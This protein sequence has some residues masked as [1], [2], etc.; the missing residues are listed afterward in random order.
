LN[1][2]REPIRII[3]D[4]HLGYSGSLLTDATQLLPLIDGVGTLVFNGDTAELRNEPRYP[5]G[6]KEFIKLQE[7]CARAGV[8][9]VFLNGNHDPVISTVNHLDLAEG[10]VLVTHGDM[11]FTDLAP[12]CKEARKIG[13]AH[14]QL[15]NAMDDHLFEDFEARLRLVKDAIVSVGLPELRFQTGPLARIAL[16][17]QKAWPPSQPFIIVRCWR[18]AA[19]RAAAMARVF[20]PRARFILIGHFHLAGITPLDPRVVVN[21]GSF[22]PLLGRLVVD[23]AGGELSVK[24]INRIRGVFSAGEEIARFPISPLPPEEV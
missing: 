24:R 20:R 16:F 18:E 3:S 14:R 9:T 23:I 12:W 13:D 10:A 8:D 19:R 21:T 11:L 4:L 22:T 7:L 1:T 15:L 5:R 17:A 2:A 6:R